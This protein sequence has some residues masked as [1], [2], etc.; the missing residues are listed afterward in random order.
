ML[1]LLLGTAGC[2]KWNLE[3]RRFPKC[4]VPAAVIA[5]KSDRLTVE[6]KLVNSTGTIDGVTWTYGDGTTSEVFTTFHTYP[7][8]GTYPVTARLRNICGD[9]VTLSGT[10]TVTDAVTPLV[11]TLAPTV[12]PPNSIQAGMSLD[13]AGNDAITQYGVCYSAVQT[14]PTLANAMVSQ[15]TG[16]PT[17]FVKYT[18]DLTQLSRG[19]TYYIRAYAVNSVGIGYGEVKYITL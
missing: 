19:T 17:P 4:D 16:Q 3:P 8:R 9:E 12:S 10:V 11:T 7:K 5:T 18:F 6:F 2:E 14:L 13:L 1:L 15:G